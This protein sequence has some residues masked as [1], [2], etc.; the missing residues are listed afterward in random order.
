MVNKFVQK[1]LTNNDIFTIFYNEWCPWSMKAIALLK[2]KNFKF[3]AYKIKDIN[4]LINNILEYP[5]LQFDVNHKTRP[6]IFKDTKFIGG[7]DK[8]VKY[9]N[10]NI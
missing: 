9:F 8:L 2:E 10:N 7:Y 6:I 5:K 4:K 3:K 1:I